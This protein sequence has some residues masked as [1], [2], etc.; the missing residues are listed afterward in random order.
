MWINNVSFIFRKVDRKNLIHITIIIIRSLL[1]LSRALHNF[2]QQ[3]FIILVIVKLLSYLLPLKIAEYNSI[4]NGTIF[5][6][7][8]FGKRYVE[9]GG[10]MQSG[11]IPYK[12]FSKGFK[13]LHLFEKQNS[14]KKILVLGLGGGTVIHLLQEKF[15]QA[16]ITA[17]DIDPVMVDAGEKF[18]GLLESSQLKI[19]IGDVFNKKTLSREQ[20]DL[21]IVDLFKGYEVPGQIGSAEF[22]YRLKSSLTKNGSVIFNRLYFQKY[23]FEANDFLDKVKKIF[24]DVH[25]VRIDFNILISAQ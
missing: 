6:K 1:Y 8:F 15:P 16:F 24:Q 23:I 25:S 18:L 20:Y 12:I 19:I 5:I 7:E 14:I 11:K 22:L 3:N 2:L 21:I 4:Y 9:V 13:K 17:I 10:L